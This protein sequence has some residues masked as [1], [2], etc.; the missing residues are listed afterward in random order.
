MRKSISRIFSRRQKSGDKKQR[1]SSANHISPPDHNLLGLLGDKD[2]PPEKLSKSEKFEVDWEPAAV[3]MESPVSSDTR[4]A[5]DPTV[6]DNRSRENTPPRIVVPS[7]L[8]DDDVMDNEMDDSILMMK[9]YDAIPVLEETKLPRGGVSIETRA[10]GR[11][12]VRAN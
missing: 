9:A 1:S 6:Q 11:I 4:A 5:S 8:V 12:Q 2:G 10:V 7:R 3:K